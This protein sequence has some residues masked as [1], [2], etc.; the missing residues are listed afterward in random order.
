MYFADGSRTAVVRQSKAVCHLAGVA[1]SSDNI[2]T[3]PEMR[4]SAAERTTDDFSRVGI[5]ATFARTA[6]QASRP[7]VCCVFNVRIRYITTNVNL[8]VNEIREKNPLTAVDLQSIPVQV[9][10]S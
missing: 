8:S 4:T 6:A 5:L 9:D 3:E 7:T 1:T 2:K 10:N